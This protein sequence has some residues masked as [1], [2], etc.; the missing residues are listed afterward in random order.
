MIESMTMPSDSQIAEIVK[1]MQKVAGEPEPDQFK[2][3]RVVQ[4][5]KRIIIPEGMTYNE[6][7]N[8]LSRQEEAEEKKVA[9]HD[10]IPCFPLDGIVALMKALKQIYGFA[11]LQDTPGFFGPTPPTLIQVPLGDGSF[12]TA[13]LGR[14]AIPKWEGGFIETAVPMEAK[15][16]IQGQIKRKFEKEVK[17]VITLAREILKNASIYKGKAIRVDLEYMDENA[18]RP[19]HPT[20]DAPQ[21]MDVESVDES[22]LI[23]NEVTEFELRANIYTLIE[24]TSACLKSNIPLKHGALFMGPFGVGK[25]LTARVL[26]KKCSRNGWTFIYLKHVQHLADALRVAQLYTPALVF[27]ED[28]DQAMTGERDEEINEILNTLDGVDTKDKPIITIL[29]TNNPDMIEPAFLRAGR[30]DTVISMDAPDEK[31][32]IRFI[33]VFAKDDDNHSLLVPDCDLVPVGKELAG[34]VPAFIGEAVQKAK[35]FA[36]SREGAN[37]TGKVTAN[38]LILA[39]KALKKHMEMVN[40]RKV[41]TD[42][43]LLMKAVQQIRAAMSGQPLPR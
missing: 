23:L 43:E 34:A 4:E 7:R 42:E 32:S 8:W 6:A 2:D 16:I 18:D 36:I 35:R 39:A 17:Q 24:Q 10:E 40:R 31:T 25:T 29:T 20:N 14:I 15:L 27:A 19:F 37:I 28:I 41:A 30:I 11:S 22:S 1:M 12:E 21:F 26:A 13:P 38:D 5:G 33:Q 9:I 3:V